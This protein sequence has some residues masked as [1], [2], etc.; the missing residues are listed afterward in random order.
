M[1]CQFF[2]LAVASLSAVSSAP[3]SGASSLTSQ[4][5]H[6]SEILSLPIPELF[7]FVIEKARQPIELSESEKNKI[8]EDWKDGS[9]KEDP[10]MLDAIM[11]LSKQ[12]DFKKVCSS[13]FNLRNLIKAL[14]AVLS[15]IL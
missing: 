3:F 14:L 7:N 12:D 15:Q 4:S 9:W 8:I 1:Y 6:R 11:G 2:T 5:C 13:V 10:M